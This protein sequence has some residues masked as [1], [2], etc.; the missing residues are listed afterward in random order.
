MLGFGHAQGSCRAAAWGHPG[1]PSIPF[2]FCNVVSYHF[3]HCRAFSSLSNLFFKLPF[4]EPRS[5]QR[6]DCCLCQ[7]YSCAQGWMWQQ[8]ISK[9]AARLSLLH[10]LA[11]SPFSL[12]CFFCRAAQPFCNLTCL[13][14]ISDFSRQ[15]H[16]VAL[17]L[18]VSLRTKR[19]PRAGEA[20][21]A[22][23][24]PPLP[25]D[26]SCSTELGSGARAAAG[27]WLR[28]EQGHWVWAEWAGSGGL[29]VYPPTSGWLRRAAGQGPTAPA[30]LN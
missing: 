1:R 6:S 3:G 14:F 29:C 13:Y 23:S 10:V 27:L 22:P 5:E 21:P 12:R 2:R 16:S 30:R 17:R 7:P 25:W 18:A 9:H 11:A 26:T 15:L 8:A 28:R 19:H 20:L 4:G 24:C